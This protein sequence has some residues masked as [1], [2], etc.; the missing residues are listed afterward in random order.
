MWRKVS[1]QHLG[2]HSHAEDLLQVRRLSVQ[3]N[4]QTHKVSL[5]LS[6]CLLAHIWRVCY[7]GQADSSASLSRCCRATRADRTELKRPTLRANST[8]EKPTAQTE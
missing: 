7:T 8:P 4:L 2:R 3:H 1:L 5:Q 6:A